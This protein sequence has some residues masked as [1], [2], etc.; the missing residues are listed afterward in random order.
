MKDESRFR[1]ASPRQK[2]HL[3]RLLEA[4]FP[5]RKEIVRQVRYA[6]VRQLDENG[7]LEFYVPRGSSAQVKR[8][9]PVEGQF[10]DADGVMIHMLLHVV[11]GMVEELEI[12]K[13]DSSLVTELPL[14]K[15]LEL[16]VFD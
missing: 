9:I 5:G 3:G 13:D 4:E 11:D 7:S 14:P 15:E 1:R 16:L 10:C 2:R 6:K 12:Y 8:R